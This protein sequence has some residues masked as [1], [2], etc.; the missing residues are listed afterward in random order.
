MVDQLSS[1]P[2][3]AVLFI[4]LQ[5]GAHL[6]LRPEV[7]V[8]EPNCALVR[9]LGIGGGGRRGLCGHVRLGLNYCRKL[10]SLRMGLFPSLPFGFH[11]FPNNFPSQPS[12]LPRAWSFLTFSN[13]CWLN[14][15]ALVKRIRQQPSRQPLCS[16]RVRGLMGSGSVYPRSHRLVVGGYSDKPLCL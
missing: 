11:H 7:L 14:T 9:Q 15:S 12:Y 13:R 3:S 8:N 16:G 4:H 1:L 5:V 10:D 2:L 6:L